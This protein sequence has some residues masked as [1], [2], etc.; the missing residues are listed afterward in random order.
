MTS[1]WIFHI[2]RNTELEALC[3]SPFPS[4][5]PAGSSS[6]GPMPGLCPNR[7]SSPEHSL[8]HWDWPRP[9]CFTTHRYDSEGTAHKPPAGKPLPGVNTPRV[10]SSVHFLDQHNLLQSSTN[11][12]GIFLLFFFSCQLLLVPCPIYKHSPTD[13]SQENTCSQPVLYLPASSSIQW[14]LYKSPL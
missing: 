1:C 2:N 5:S 3:P 6:P 9:A 12:S 4:P 7:D 11:F 8:L 14:V 10:Y 13:L